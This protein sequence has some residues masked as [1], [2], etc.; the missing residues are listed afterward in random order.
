MAKIIKKTALGFQKTCD[1]LGS[2]EHNFICNG[3][4]CHNCDFPNKEQMLGILQ[5]EWGDRVIPLSIDT[6]ARPKSA[7]KDVERYMNDKVSPETEILTKGMDG[8][9]QNVSGHDWLFGY[10]D[11]EGNLVDGEFDKNLDLKK[12]AENNPDLWQAIVKSIG[13]IRQKGSH[14]S[15]VAILPEAAQNIMPLYRVGG[16]KEGQLVTGFGPK[17][18]ENLGVMKV[19]IL[20]VK[21]MA[22]IAKCFQLIKEKTGE[23][24]IWEE[25]KHEPD[26]YTKVIHVGRTE[27]LFQLQTPGLT[28]LCKKSKPNS[29]VELSNLIALYRPGCLDWDMSDCGFEGNAVSY[30]VE[31]AAGNFKPFYIHPDLEPILNKSFGVCLMQEQT[32]RIFRDIGGFTY[33]T[34]ET[35]RRAIGK[36]DAKALEE[37]FHQ[38]EQKCLERGWSE[39]NVKS[40]RNMIMASSKYSFNASHSVSYGIVAYNTA[41][42]KYFYPLEFWCAELSIEQDEDTL[43]Q[44]ANL[45][46]DI[47]IQPD[48][49]ISHPTEWTI[50]DKRLVAPLNRIKGVGEKAAVDI[51]RLID[52]DFRRLTVEE[53]VA[54]KRT[55]KV[56]NTDDGY[57]S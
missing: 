35:V 41:W 7:I 16:F 31:C 54:Q 24:L 38:L 45:L 33:E 6:L 1:L 18:C 43:S 12:Y 9:P 40:L 34:A 15:G 42:L 53:I 37:A 5:A 14:A 23:T 4:V 44:Y 30:Y 50:Q 20:G 57:D 29:I 11:N 22:V 48:V 46:G 36:K 8:V 51:R 2:N 32:L 56:K 49:M 25:F 47:L 52:G 3:I 10:L 13:T 55:K 19:D 21:K 27:G 28:N 26:V 17:D 39:P